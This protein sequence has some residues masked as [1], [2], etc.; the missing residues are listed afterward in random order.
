MF[1]FTFLLTPLRANPTKCSNTL[2]QFF[3]CFIRIVWVFDR[4]WVYFYVQTQSLKLLTSLKQRA[5]LKRHQYFSCINSSNLYQNT[6]TF[7]LGN[8]MLF[9]FP[10]RKSFVASLISRLCTQ[11]FYSFLGTL[12]FNFVNL[13]FEK[14]KEKEEAIVLVSS[15]Y[16]SI[17]I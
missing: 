13:E 1:F 3:G 11:N 16:F 2:K 8:H 10:F 17:I 15:F 14:R 4:L 12:C 7:S 9:F 6:G 5:T